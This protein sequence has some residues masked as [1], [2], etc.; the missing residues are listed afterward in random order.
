MKNTIDMR[1]IKYN[2]KVSLILIGN[3]RIIDVF[4]SSRLKGYYKYR[5]VG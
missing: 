3:S 1:I 2:I 5:L 4:F